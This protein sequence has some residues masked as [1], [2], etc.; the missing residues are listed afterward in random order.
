MYC[1]FYFP[2]S[3]PLRNRKGINKVKKLFRSNQQAQKKILYQAYTNKE[4]DRDLTC[5]QKI[6]RSRRLCGTPIVIAVTSLKSG[7]GCSHVAISIA[8]YLDERSNEDY[9]CFFTTNKNDPIN[10]LS[11]YVT[12][13]KYNFEEVSQLIDGEDYDYLIIDFGNMDCLQSWR[14]ALTEIK[15]ADIKI[16]L[17]L[18]EDD[19]LQSLTKFIQEQSSTARWNFLFN[20]VVDNNQK[21]IYDLMEDYRTYCLPVYDKADVMINKELKK[22]FKSL[23]P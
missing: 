6:E 3:H 2:K 10:C 14:G 8:S 1:H 19:Y 18:Q 20:H 12:C 4:I 11:Q 7:S 15:R 21:E 17:C 23:L 16:M 22:Y 5:K 9:V 13:K